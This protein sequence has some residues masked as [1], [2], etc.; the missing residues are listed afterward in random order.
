MWVDQSGSTYTNW[1]SGE[2]N[3][4]KN[5]GEDC[6]HMHSEL[7]SREYKWND[8]RCDG[9]YNIPYVCETRGKSGSIMLYVVQPNVKF[10]YQSLS[11]L[12]TKNQRHRP[13]LMYKKKKLSYVLISLQ[14]FGRISKHYWFKFS[15]TSCLSPNQCRAFIYLG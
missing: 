8:L 2:P 3:D 4:Y 15:A 6:V 14:Y 10:V 5:L 9:S 12:N 13:S 11:R 1:D 7:E